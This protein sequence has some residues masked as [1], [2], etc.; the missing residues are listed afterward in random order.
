LPA[1]A[2]WTDP[3]SG[4]VADGG[5]TVTTDAPLARIPVYLREGKQADIFR[6]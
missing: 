1:G 6:S 4:Q 3:W 2:A 5:R